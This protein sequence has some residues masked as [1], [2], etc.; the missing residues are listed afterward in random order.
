MGYRCVNG[1]YHV[2]STWARA[3]DLTEAW[4]LGADEHNTLSPLGRHLAS[5][6]ARSEKST[7]IAVQTSARLSTEWYNQTAF[8]R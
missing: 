1:H 8:L 2:S 4:C 3:Y 6:N 5:G 7:A